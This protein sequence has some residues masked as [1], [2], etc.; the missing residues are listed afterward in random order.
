MANIDYDAFGRTL[1]QTGAGNEAFLFVGEPRDQVTGLTYL[2]ARYLDPQTG[3][4]IA[5]DP[6]LGSPEDP[7]SLHRYLYAN[8]NP[9]NFR[10][11]SG[12]LTLTEIQIVSGI[13]SALVL[14]SISQ[15]VVASRATSG[16][17]VQWDGPTGFFTVEAPLEPFGGGV[18]LSLLESQQRNGRYTQAI[19]FLFTLNASTPNFFKKSVKKSLR[20]PP[21]NKGPKKGRKAR[22]GRGTDL[23]GFDVLSL[24]FAGPLSLLNFDLQFDDTTLFSPSSLGGENGIQPFVLGGFYS[25]L[26]FAA[27]G[28]LLAAVADK[29]ITGSF[30]SSIGISG[31]LQ[32]FGVGYDIKDTSLALVPNA[33]I[34]LFA[35]VSADFTLPD[36]VNQVDTRSLE[37]TGAD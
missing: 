29:Q 36:R 13:L 5:A 16:L 24:V 1:E 7:L 15:A 27:S 6:F 26:E 14:A 10:D 17:D 32:G 20:P 34:E 19:H 18:G 28:G 2:R 11:P 25:R 35:G 31:T 37:E 8:A 21:R 9:V 3:Q 22:R 30:K 12:L 33:N 23:T 4:F